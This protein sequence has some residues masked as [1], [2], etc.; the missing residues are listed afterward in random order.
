MLCCAHTSTSMVDVKDAR[1][2][3][4]GTATL[5]NERRHT[6]H[7]VDQPAAGDGMAAKPT[8]VLLHGF[9]D[10]WLAGTSLMSCSL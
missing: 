8:C 6:Y 7:Y 3:T 10:L 9:P 4:Q 2:F 5:Q 1:A